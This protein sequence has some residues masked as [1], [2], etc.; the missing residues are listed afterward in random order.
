[1]TDQSIL[2]A[3]SPCGLSCEK[4]FAHIDGDV[5]RLSRQLSKKLGNFD[6]DAKRFETLVGP[7][8]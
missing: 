2:E 5:R 1:M 6:I 7:S 8:A 4:C 3:L